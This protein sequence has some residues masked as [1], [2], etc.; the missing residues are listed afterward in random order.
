MAKVPRASDD[1]GYSGISDSPDKGDGVGDTRGV[2]YA[3]KSTADKHDSIPGQHK[4]NRAYAISRGLMIEAEFDDE[5]VSGYSRSRGPGL[6]AA[7]AEAE[8]IAAEYGRSFLLVA[9]ANRLARG[10]GVQAK[11]LFEYVLWARKKNVLLL[12]ASGENVADPIYAVL[13]GESSHA[14]SRSKSVL[15]REGKRRAVA[16]RGKRNGGPR[17]FGYQHVRFIDPEGRAESRLE[18]VPGEAKAIRRMVEESLDGRSQSKIARGLNESGYRTTRGRNWTQGR[19]SHT[20]ANRLYAGFVEYCGEW[21]QGVHEPI[22]EPDTW[23]RLQRSLK[24]RRRRGSGKG[25]RPTEGRHLLTHGLLR[26]ACGAPMRVR[27]ERKDYGLYEV[28]LCDGRHSGAT[29]CQV[30]ALQREP[31]DKAVWRYVEEFA[32]DLQATIE[33]AHERASFEL[34]DIRSQLVA[35]ERDLSLTTDRYSLVREDYLGQRITAEAWMELR[36]EMRADMRGAKAA[37][38]RLVEREAEVLAAFDGRDGEEAVAQHLA[39]IRAAI[40]GALSG[41]SA[42]DDARS[43]LWGL[44]EALI[45]HVDGHSKPILSD[46]DLDY[47]S[48]GWVIEPIVREEAILQ[49]LII[50]NDEVVQSER[51]RPITLRSEEPIAS[52][53]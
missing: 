53:R 41:V 3:A 1:A 5:A 30:P 31:I 37:A 24:E 38:G 49:P 28:Y 23:E 45:I 36:E 4:F 8:R 12:A 15:T 33:A 32:L 39:Q 42:L 16:L 50:E 29:A 22:I 25:G 6:T 43:A 35:A 34:N 13:L 20:L 7:I 10:D 40:S 11:H 27:A 18:I 52:R 14:D 47:P 48:H 9:T 44:F 26:C 21:F 2:S 19:V 51:L 17:P 46:G